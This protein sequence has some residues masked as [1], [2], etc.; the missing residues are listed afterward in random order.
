MKT[1]TNVSS[2][3]E[4]S[5]NS[6]AVASAAGLLMFIRFL[7]DDLLYYTND[8]MYMLIEDYDVDCSS[9]LEDAQADHHQGQ[10]LQVALIRQVRNHH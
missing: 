6:F 10:L 8:L 9:L 2:V 3:A 7:V 5:P 1:N 4:N